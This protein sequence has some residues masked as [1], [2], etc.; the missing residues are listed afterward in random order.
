MSDQFFPNYTIGANAYDSIVPICREFGKTAVIIGGN[1]SR[2]KAEPKIRR[3][4]EGK[5]AILGS[6]HYGDDATFENAE[7]LAKIPE[8]Q[9]ADLVFAVG[10]GRA[11]D[12]VKC[13]AAKSGKPVFTFPTLASNCASVTAVCLIYYPDH[14]Y[15][16]NWYRTRPSYHTFIDT[17]I[18]AASPEEYLWAGIGDALSKE[19]EVLFSA[20]GD[21][22]PYGR[23][24]GVQLAKNCSEGLF[25]YGEQALQDLRERNVTEALEYVAQNIILSTGLISNLVPMDYN[26]SLAHAIYNSY[27][28]IP[29]EGES[30]HGAVVVY[31][32]L[33]LLT[34]DGQTEN[35]DRLLEFTR[36]VKLPHKLADIGIQTSEIE[37]LAEAAL[38]K[39][40][41]KKVPY[42][43]T[44]EKLVQAMKDLEALSQEEEA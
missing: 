18:I 34:L 36:R 19:Y 35:R 25:Q 12:T 26:S 5:I 4:V 42:P 28:Q 39:P 32:T 21:A 15:R 10:G 31:G 41:V 40:D 27:S 43:I 8:V 13:M 33:V 23:S 9:E 22:L 7:R 24:I 37:A 14:S 11:V 1:I 20:R 38:T 6:Y 3:A 16:E 2:E 17:E 44:K 30:L 29:H